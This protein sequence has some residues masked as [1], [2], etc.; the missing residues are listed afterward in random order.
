MR[1]ATETIPVL[2]TAEATAL[3]A[4]KIGIDGGELSVGQHDVDF[5]VRIAGYVRQ[6]AASSMR[7]TVAIPLLETVALALNY[8]G[9]TRDAAINAIE[10]A[11]SA[12]MERQISPKGSG[13]ILADD[14]I[15]GGQI[16]SMIERF[17]NEVVEN[18]PRIP[19]KGSLTNKLEVTPIESA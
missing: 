5:T 2:S 7:P 8:A 14:A 9:I 17:Q 18:L 15:D 6:G 4:A 10:Q 16:A 11:M 13:A 19:R 3:K 1:Q 12:V